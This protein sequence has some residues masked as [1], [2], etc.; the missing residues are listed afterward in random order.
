MKFEAGFNFTSTFTE[1]YL[2]NTDGSAGS[3]FVSYGEDV[4]KYL[5]VSKSTSTYTKVPAQ[6]ELD[7]LGFSGKQVLSAISTT[8]KTETLDPNGIED[9]FVSTL[10][11]AQWQDGSGSA[12]EVKTLQFFSFKGSHRKQSAVP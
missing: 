3:H 10:T 7:R 2:K 8:V 12:A 6:E 4:T 5:Q 9:H 1:C 11:T